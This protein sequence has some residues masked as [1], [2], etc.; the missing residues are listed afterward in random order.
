MHSWPLAYPMRT[1]EMADKPLKA[2]PPDIILE[3]KTFSTDDKA[4]N[5]NVHT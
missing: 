4:A 3:D 2:L 5:V 1:D